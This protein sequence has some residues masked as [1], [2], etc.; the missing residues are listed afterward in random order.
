MTLRRKSTATA[1]L[2]A[3]LALTLAASA[4]AAERIGVASAVQ[5]EVSGNMGGGATEL[6]SGDGVFR[7]QTITSA[8]GGSAQFLFLDE[9]VFSVGPNT[10]VVLDEFVYNGAATT[11]TVLLNVSKGAFRFITGD[12]A[13]QSYSI[14]TPTATI[15]VRGTIFKGIVDSVLSIITLIQGKLYICPVPGAKIEGA[16]PSKN[17]ANAGDCVLIEEPGTY[18]VGQIIGE[19]GEPNV[20]GDDPNDAIDDAE[21]T[22]EMED[23]EFDYYDEC[24]ECFFNDF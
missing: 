13:P 4:P 16:D 1:S 7:N 14:R 11:G 3:L 23:D 6:G 18:H 5:P 22:F 9:T 10:E 19:D 8:A 12:A 15:G 24:G 20:P 21:E 17:P 2:A